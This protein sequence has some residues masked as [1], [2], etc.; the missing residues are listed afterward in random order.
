M[1]NLK[2]KL[3]HYKFECR[4]PGGCINKQFILTQIEEAAPELLQLDTIINPDGFI[5]SLSTTSN[6]IQIPQRS[7]GIASTQ[8]FKILLTE[9]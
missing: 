1:S 6:D 7:P 9:Y 4:A 3:I 2:Q 8:P 5:I